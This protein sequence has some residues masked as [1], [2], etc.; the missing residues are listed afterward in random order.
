MEVKIERRFPI[1]AN[2]ACAWKVLEDVKRTAS[3]MPGAQITEQLDETKFKGIVK[4]KVGPASFTFGGDIE[5]LEID[6]AQN[7]IRMHG[8]GAD[9]AGSTAAMTL[10]ASIE[11]GAEQSCV[12][13]GEATV[14]VG[15][16][17]A[18]FGNRLIIPVMD[19]LLLQFAKNFTQQ[20]LAVAATQSVVVTTS[21]VAAASSPESRN[22]ETV[23][24]P[25]T[26]PS[27]S[28]LNVFSLAMTVIKGY[29][30]RLFGKS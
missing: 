6:Q 13:V 15:G 19:A 8:K 9:K 23:Q 22:A 4:S 25:A 1:A 14:S 5:V 12:L 29:F 11:E 26:A 20:G 3:C 30:S 7:R 18:Q 24:P 10:V 17:L 21:S 16:K 28:E 2:A 27:S